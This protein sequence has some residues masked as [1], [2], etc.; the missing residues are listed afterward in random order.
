M[1]VEERLELGRR[2]C[3]MCALQARASSACALRMRVV[4][5]LDLGLDRLGRDL[6]VRHFEPARCE[7]RCA[8][9]D[10]DPAGHGDSRAAK[11]RGSFA[12]A[13][14]VR[15]QLASAAIA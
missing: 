12:F 15:D 11:L 14:L 9:P 4:E 13:E 5:A 8:L 10:G 6:V 2:P 1:Q 3:G 7:T